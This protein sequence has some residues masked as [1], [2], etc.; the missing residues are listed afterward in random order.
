MK[1][2][3][4]VSLQTDL[5][6]HEKQMADDERAA[7]AASAAALQQE[8]TART[9]ERWEAEKAADRAAAEIASLQ[10]ALAVAQDAQN[11]AAR[12]LEEIRGHVWEASKR[13]EVAE[14]EQ[15]A[16]IRFVSL[17]VEYRYFTLSMQYFK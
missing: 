17:T 16:A 14:A 2:F 9:K 1:W 10:Q 7:A 15:K 4:G 6:D 3:H 8:K 11:D 5:F 12:K 13:A